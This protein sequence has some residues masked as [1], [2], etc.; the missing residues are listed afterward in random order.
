MGVSGAVWLDADG[1]GRRTDARTYA[2]RLIDASRGEIGA[3][4]SS[5]APYDEAVATQAAAL[6]LERGVLP[7]NDALREALRRAAPATRRGF[8]A[9]GEEWRA[10]EAARAAARR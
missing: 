6:L 3:L 1:D 2:A 5:L 9:F 4:V 10:S 8:A 7:S